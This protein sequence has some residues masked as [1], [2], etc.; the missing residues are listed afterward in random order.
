MR[1]KVFKRNVLSILTV[2]FALFLC[3]CT[4]AKKDS[5]WIYGLTIDD[6]WYESISKEDVIEGLKNLNHKP[7]V[8]IVMSK[9][10]LAEDYVPLFKAAAKYADIMACP[11][12]SSQ[13][14]QYKDVDSYVKRFKDAYKN[15]SPYVSVWE[16]GNEVNGIEWIKQDSALIAE[17]ISCAAKFI[18]NK[19]AKTE[20]TL[21]CT[22]LPEK[23]M[24]QWVKKY[25]SSE[26]TE[27][28]DYCFVSYY[29]DDNGGYQPDWDD[30]FDKLGKY[31]PSSLLGIG[32][33]GNTDKNATV[34]SK[35]A[36]IKKYYGMKRVHERFVGGFFWW[37]WVE[38]CIPYEE[39]Q[40]YELINNYGY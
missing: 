22:D 13:M 25:I 36:R 38:D 8:R 29:E 19:G 9:E 26:V 4:G 17:K 15:L 34:A 16:I 40:L 3:G 14:N 27:T 30:I 7:M 23:D 31:F 5:N 1:K 37:N 10:M 35:T 11:V 2:V 21:Y 12:D 32:E 39:N 28:M 33:C 6:A 18:K 20:L 24:L